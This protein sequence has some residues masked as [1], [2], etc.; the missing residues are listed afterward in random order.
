MGSRIDG[1]AV[2]VVESSGHVAP[3]AGP[4]GLMQDEGRA[5]YGIDSPAM[6]GAFAMGAFA[7]SM[8]P[9]LLYVGGVVLHLAMTPVFVL[10]T[11]PWLTGAECALWLTFGTSS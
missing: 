10:S 4:G 6:V 2:G 9:R 8:P 5:N 3:A 7:R 1:G 11:L